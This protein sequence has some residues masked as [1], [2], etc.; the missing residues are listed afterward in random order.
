MTRDN[1]KTIKKLDKCLFKF[2]IKQD[3]AKSVIQ[4]TDSV[5]NSWSMSSY[6]FVLEPNMYIHAAHAAHNSIE[7]PT[8]E[9]T[10]SPSSLAWTLEP[11]ELM[12][13]DVLERLW[14]RSSPKRFTLHQFERITKSI[15]LKRNLWDFSKGATTSATS[16]ERLEAMQSRVYRF[17]FQLDSLNMHM[18]P[19]IHRFIMH[20]RHYTV[21]GAASSMLHSCT[22]E[23]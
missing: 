4:K 8:S 9:V 13:T 21:C 22:W 5:R 2:Q 12:G 17:I 14:P 20:P 16:E 19:I 11:S 10:C 1:V 18:R 23:T 15:S 3:S 7:Q 6:S